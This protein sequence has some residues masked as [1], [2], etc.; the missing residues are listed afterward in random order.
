MKKQK[1]KEFEYPAIVLVEACAMANGELIHFGK[2]LGFMNERQVEL[3]EKGAGKMARGTEP[4]VA[5]G[6]KVA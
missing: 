5:I 4:V 1:Q 3:L 6:D 2:S